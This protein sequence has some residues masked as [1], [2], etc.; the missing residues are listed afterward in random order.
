MIDGDK[1]LIA[2]E[3]RETGGPP[4][5]PPDRQ[6]FGTT[7]IEKMIK[8]VFRGSVVLDYRREGLVCRM[9]FPRAN[10]EQIQAVDPEA[11]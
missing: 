7:L 6:G 10:V 4:V 9:T 3:W 1:G 8:R 11:M 2:I 5:Q